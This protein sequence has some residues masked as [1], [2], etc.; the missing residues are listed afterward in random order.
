MQRERGA[1]PVQE[2]VVKNPDAGDFEIVGD[3]IRIDRGLVEFHQREGGFRRRNGVAD[4]LLGIAAIGK[5]VVHYDHVGRRKEIEKVAGHGRK[6]GDGA[7]FHSA[8]GVVGDQ[9]V[10]CAAI[11]PVLPAVAELVVQ[12]DRR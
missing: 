12:I 7:Q 8:D 10:V 6:T 2:R 5:H 9:R 1:P 3:V 4:G 11:Y